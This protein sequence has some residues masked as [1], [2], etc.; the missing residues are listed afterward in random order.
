MELAS[1]VGLP[2]LRRAFMD[3]I[4]LLI[5]ISAGA[6]VVRY[7]ER[8]RYFVPLRHSASSVLVDQTLGLARL[9]LPDG[10]RAARDLNETASIEAINA[11]FGRHV[12][13]ISDAVEDFVPEMTVYEHSTNTRAEL[14][15]S[16]RL[17]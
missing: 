1:W 9:E 5:T 16:I 15:N 12:I 3:T 11:L 17:I 2:T 7:K 14:A 10:W 8:L 13:V 4:V 6:L